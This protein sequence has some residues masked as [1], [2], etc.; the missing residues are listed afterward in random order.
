MPKLD[1]GHYNL[2]TCP[3]QFYNVLKLT[4][5]YIY[6]LQNKPSMSCS[7]IKFKS[8]HFISIYFLPNTRLRC[9]SAY[10]IVAWMKH[11][12]SIDYSALLECWKLIVLVTTEIKLSG[13]WWGTMLAV[14][15]PWPCIIIGIPIRKMW[16]CETSNLCNGNPCTVFKR[17]LRS[18]LINRRFTILVL[19]LMDC[20]IYWC[21]CLISLINMMKYHMFL[22]D[23][24]KVINQGGV[25]TCI[26]CCFVLLNQLVCKSKQRS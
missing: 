12:G 9:C 17:R 24:Y 10:V 25:S 18:F 16:W 6:F 2:V 14:I 26:V 7:F 15:V 22:Y 11:A 3:I 4:F 8:G 5:T 1:H 20:R 23:D 13:Y 19:M 21:W